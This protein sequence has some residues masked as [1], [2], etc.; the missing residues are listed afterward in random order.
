[1]YDS[2][3]YAV[4]LRQ[5]FTFDMYPYALYNALAFTEYKKYYFSFLD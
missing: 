2:K 5:I 1:M 3:T 4:L